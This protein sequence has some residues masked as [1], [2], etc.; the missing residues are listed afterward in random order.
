MEACHAMATW[1][2]CAYVEMHYNMSSQ[3]PYVPMNARS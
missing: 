1:K 3:L 2:C